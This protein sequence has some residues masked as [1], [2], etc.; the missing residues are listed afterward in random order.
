MTDPVSYID[1]TMP[2]AGCRDQGYYLCEP[3]S[4]AT[5]EQR[6][7][8]ARLALS[9]AKVGER[10][11]M[12]ADLLR[13]C[14]FLDADAIPEEIFQAGAEE[15]EETLAVVTNDRL[16]LTSAI[17]EASRYS[18]LLRH[19][20]SRT[21]SLSRLAQVTL[22][23]E[24]EESERRR[25]A[26]VAVRLLNRAF[27]LVEYDNWLHCARLVPHVQ[28]IAKAIDEFDFVFPEAARLLHQAGYYLL[29]R[30]QYEKAELL[31][32]Q[33][34]QMDETIFGPDHPRVATV[35]NNLATLLKDTNRMAEAEL[36]LRRALQI[37]E[38]QFGSDDQIVAVD[39]NNLATLLQATSRL[40]EAELLM[41]RALQMDEI[42]FGPDHPR[43]AI[44]LNNLATL[45]KDTYRL[46]EAESLLRR[47]VDIFEKSLGPD[48]PYTHIGAENYNAVRH[49]FTELRY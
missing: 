17:D 19:P 26:E 6:S 1:S 3:H 49:E 28:E 11:P 42:N 44:N 24:M 41:R 37:D 21:F 38:N 48:H 35:L 20:Q 4:I 40:T 14:A 31:M 18:L 2:G 12:A 15:L 29:E 45:L 46:A 13:V 34:L 8:V 10:S 30:A 25:W 16:K 32:R 7:V 22:Q 9:L 36:M 5:D 23:Y 47:V 39:L 43:V 27:P 33:A